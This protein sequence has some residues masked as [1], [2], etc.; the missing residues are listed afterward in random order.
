MK[1]TKAAIIAELAASSLKPIVIR[2]GT[3]ERHNK[4]MNAESNIL[5]ETANMYLNKQL[6]ICLNGATHAVVVGK[7]KSLEHGKKV[8]EKL[9]RHPKNLRAMYQHPE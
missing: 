6:E 3:V 8:M 2:N 7:A 9:E 5:H 1:Q 4:R